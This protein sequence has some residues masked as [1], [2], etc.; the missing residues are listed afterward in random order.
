MVASAP[1]QAGKTFPP[2]RELVPGAGELRAVFQTNHGTFT[3]RLFEE[4]AP[5]TVANFVGLATGKVEWTDPRTGGA[6]QGPY[7]DGVDFHRIIDGF[8]IQGG[9]P[10]GTG[11]GGP[12]Y[13]FDDECSASARHTKAGILS[14]ANAGSRAGRGTNG[15]QFFVTL[16]DTPHLD[17]KHT[18]FGE[19]VDGLDVV[20][21]IGKVRT[22][23]QDRPVSPVTIERLEIRRG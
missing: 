16:R 21:R 7:Y 5:N 4:V 14:M 19:V 17:G 23:P 9:D 18:V 3:A 15:S 22:G 20:S 10:T 12:G 2:A 13:N 1:V 11:R 6:G 8:M